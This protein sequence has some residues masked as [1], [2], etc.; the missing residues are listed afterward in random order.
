MSFRDERDSFKLTIASLTADSYYSWS[1][2]MEIVLGRKGLWKFVGGSTAKPV[3]LR[4]DSLLSEYKGD[5]RGVDEEL[6]GKG[7]EQ[8]DLA[9]EYILKSVDS[10]CKALIW[11]TRCPRLAQTTI[12]EASKSVSVAAIDV[13]PT[14]AQ[15]VGL[16][17]GKRTVVYASRI[18]SLETE[19]DN[20]GLAV[21]E[22][23]TKRAL[24][25][26]M[27]GDYD[28]TLVAIMGVLQTYGEAVPKLIVGESRLCMIEDASPLALVTSTEQKQK[29]QKCFVSRK[30]GH[31][32]RDCRLKKIG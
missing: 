14:Q 28:M 12:E 11:Q 3:D 2:D 6:S 23:K 8:K 31:A 15:A 18:L 1:D 4:V 22:V 29:S 17:K 9:L 19:P 5:D 27:L 16:L 7:K 26:G 32:A 24:F 20:A 13:K 30:P 25:R 10:S 21:L